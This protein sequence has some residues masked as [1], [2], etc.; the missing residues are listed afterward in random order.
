MPNCVA[1][2]DIVL[3]LGD[4]NSNYATCY[5]EDDDGGAETMRGELKTSS[6][7]CVGKPY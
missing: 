7:A 3:A 6:A 2:D 4:P 5:A 1:D